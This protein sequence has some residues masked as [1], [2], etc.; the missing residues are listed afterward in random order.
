MINASLL[1]REQRKC[2]ANRKEPVGVWKINKS[3]LKS[4]QQM[5]PTDKAIKEFYLWMQLDVCLS[6]LLFQQPNLPLV[7]CWSVTFKVTQ[8]SP[9][10][11][12]QPMPPSERV[13]YWPSARGTPWYNHV[14]SM[15][16]LGEPSVG[17]VVLA[18]TF[19]SW[20]MFRNKGQRI[21]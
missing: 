3:P 6:L 18:R 20:L 2:K 7:P 4:G 13:R 12:Q 1:T 9:L 14:L 19:G 16:L 5:W 11:S 15:A 10:E 17:Y 21:L 8:F